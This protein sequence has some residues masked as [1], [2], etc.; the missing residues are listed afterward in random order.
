MTLSTLK[1]KR[2]EVTD[3]LPQPI[4]RAEKMV[5][6]SFSNPN[7]PPEGTGEG[8]EKPTAFS[9]ISRQNPRFD[10]PITFLPA[11]LAEVDRGVP[12]ENFTHKEVLKVKKSPLNFSGSPSFSTTQ[13]T[14]DATILVG[15]PNVQKALLR[16]K[17]RMTPRGANISVG[18]ALQQNSP[19]DL[20]ID[21]SETDSNDMMG[22]DSSDESSPES[23]KATKGEATPTLGAPSPPS[24]QKGWRQTGR[25]SWYGGRWAGR[26]T[27]SGERFNPRAYTA[28]HR[29]LP[30]GTEI[31]VRRPDNQRTV[32]V[33]IN[34]RGPYSGKRILDLSKA[35]AAKLDMIRTGVAH[36]ELQVLALP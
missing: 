12:R 36:V 20:T 8:S 10:P 2:D 32:R 14:S 18:Q 9:E 4:F 6:A 24:F 33:R 23:P 22:L 15:A 11:L 29:K 13:S 35:A 25:A 1:R 21:G 30:L 28:A 5:P 3:T 34:D 16:L 19:I 27:A 7:F 26:K 17:S 31:E